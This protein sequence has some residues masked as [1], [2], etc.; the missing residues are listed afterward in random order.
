MSSVLSE[1]WQVLVGFIF[2]V[3]TLIL[4]TLVERYRRWRNRPIILVEPHLAVTDGEVLSVML[5]VRNVGRTALLDTTNRLFVN[6]PQLVVEGKLARMLEDNQIIKRA[7]WYLVGEGDSYESQDVFP[8]PDIAFLNLAAFSCVARAC[9]V[10]FFP[11]RNLIEL[12]GQKDYLAFSDSTTEVRPLRTLRV[13]MIVVLRGKTVY[14]E[15]IQRRFAFLL[16]IPN[17][18]GPEACDFAKATI[19]LIPVKREW[20]DLSSFMESHGISDFDM[21]KAVPPFQARRG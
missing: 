15:T 6:A 4:G 2:G 13:M 14:D 1:Y 8:M 21:S 12:I 7:P 16:E 5:E 10:S 11:D 9:S 3:A 18:G 19:V 17:F 20:E